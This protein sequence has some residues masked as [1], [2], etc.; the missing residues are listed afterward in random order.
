MSEY[1]SDQLVVDTTTAETEAL[2]EL[3]DELSASHLPAEC[4]DSIDDTFSSEETAPS[5]GGHSFGTHYGNDSSWGNYTFEFSYGGN[6][7][8]GSGN[9]DH[10]ASSFDGSY[11]HSKETTNP[12]GFADLMY[13]VAESN[14]MFNPISISQNPLN[15]S[16]IDSQGIGGLRGAG[17]QELKMKL[18]ENY[19]IVENLGGEYSFSAEVSDFSYC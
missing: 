15:F 13:R 12:N 1:I 11:D 19:G 14:A 2:R 16:H 5:Y 17:S 6:N 3:E 10:F 8:D 4:E 7:D 9:E 18:F